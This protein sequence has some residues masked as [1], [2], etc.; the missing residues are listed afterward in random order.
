MILD[1]QEAKAALKKAQGE[2]DQEISLSM[3]LRLLV[4]KYVAGKVRI[5]EEK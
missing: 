2:V 4:R 1:D 3:L 5:G